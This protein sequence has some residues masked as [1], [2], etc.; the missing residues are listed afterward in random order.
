MKTEVK[1]SGVLT[2]ST[3]DCL[4]H[5]LKQL[6]WGKSAKLSRAEKP[7]IEFIGITSGTIRRWFL[8]QVAPGGMPLLKLRY[9]LESNGY[10]VTDLDSLEKPVRRLGEI[11]SHGIVDFREMVEQIGYKQ[12]TELLQV[13][14]GRRGLSNERRAKIEEICS[15]H[16]LEKASVTLRAV[17]SVEHPIPPLSTDH[18]KNVISVEDDVFNLLISLNGLSSLL[19]PRLEHM[20]SNGFT[21]AQRQ[22]FRDRAGQGL[23][24]KLS[25]RFYALNKLLNALCSEKAREITSTNQR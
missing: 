1:P 9:F 15:K 25:N 16:P 4:R 10:Q 18:E 3:A 23:V 5:Y 22:A 13:L 12:D 20:L 17:A 24:F 7:M 6:P 14:H 21:S 19:T 11:I 8:E 2:G